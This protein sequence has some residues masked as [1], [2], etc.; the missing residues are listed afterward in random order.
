MI[1]PESS[2]YRPSDFN[3]AKVS[4]IHSTIDID[5]A[6][7]KLDKDPVLEHSHFRGNQRYII[8]LVNT[9]I[10]HLFCARY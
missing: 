5:D 2:P 6:K 1:E 3:L 10:E 4:L 9:I 7:T 8:M